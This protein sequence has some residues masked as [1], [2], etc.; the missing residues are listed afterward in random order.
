MFLEIIE[1]RHCSYMGKSIFED[2]VKGVMLL[3]NFVSLIIELGLR[4]MIIGTFVE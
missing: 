4:V 2:R 3:I 1:E